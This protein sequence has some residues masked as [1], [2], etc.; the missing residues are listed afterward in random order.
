MQAVD[1]LR[2]D[3]AHPA[4]LDEAGERTVAGVGRRALERRMGRELAPPG[5]A[6]R[7]CRGEEVAELDRLVPGPDAPG[8]AEIGNARLGGDAGAGEGDDVVRLGDHAPQRVDGVRR[9]GSDTVP[10]SP[11]TLR[12]PIGLRPADRTPRSIDN[13]H[14]PA[15]TGRRSSSSMDTSSGP[16]M[17]AILTPGRMVVSSRVN[18]APLAFSWAHTA[19][20]FST[21]KPK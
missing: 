14:E 13:S 18:V 21:S 3:R 12:I 2:D 11:I 19:S 6:A 7:L 16:A 1:V 4:L 8:R 20:M 5:L 10:P 15:A 9:S 17:K